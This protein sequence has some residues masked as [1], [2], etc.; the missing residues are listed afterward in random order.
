M[1]CCIFRAL[2]FSEDLFVAP[3]AKLNAGSSRKSE[4]FGQCRGSNLFFACVQCAFSLNTIDGLVV[5][6]PQFI[7]QHNTEKQ[8]CSLTMNQ[9]GDLTAVEYRFYVLGSR[10]ILYSETEHEGS[11]FLPPYGASLPPSVDWRTKGYVTPVKNQGISHYLSFTIILVVYFYCKRAL[12]K[13]LTL[14]LYA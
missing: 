10:S 2:V 14:P 3:V 4:T 9:F 11:T 1:Y 6:F 8:S 7:K 13:F 12:L 5:S